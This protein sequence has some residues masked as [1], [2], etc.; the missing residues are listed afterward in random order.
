[1]VVCLLH[2]VPVFWDELGLSWF[3]KHMMLLRVTFA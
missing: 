3:I 1:M 2:G